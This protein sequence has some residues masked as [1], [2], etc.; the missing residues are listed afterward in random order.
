MKIVFFNGPPRSGKDTA[1]NEIVY[2]LGDNWYTVENIG[3][4]DH[5]KLATHVAYGLPNNTTYNE[6]EAV[7][8]EPRREFFGKTPRQAYIAFSDYMKTLHGP[9]IFG[10]MYARTVLHSG[11]DLVVNP[12]SGFADELEPVL[13]LLGRENAILIRIHRPG[14]DFAG[15]SRS[16]IELP[17]VKTFDVEN[18][19]TKFEFEDLVSDI[20]RECL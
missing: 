4:A 3:L 18:S 2:R 9:S 19:G 5:I 12:S 14:Q 6:F 17:G 15:D 8:D 11:C 13:D 10:E 20:V 1:A 7:K 16:Y